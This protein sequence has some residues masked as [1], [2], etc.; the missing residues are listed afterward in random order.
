MARTA[1][2]N[3]RVYRLAEALADE[4]WSIVQKWD[5]FARHTVGEQ[6]VNAADSIGANIA[7]GVGRGTYK[8]NR[9]FVRV[10]RGSLNETQHFLRRAYCRRLMTEQ[11]VTKLKPIVDELAPSLNA[12]LASIGTQRREA[13]EKPRP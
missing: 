7:E 5:S 2:E 3:L 6:L 13:K 1:F 12:Y 8:E 4:I 10:A 11:D 9:R